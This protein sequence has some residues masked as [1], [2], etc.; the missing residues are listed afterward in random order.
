MNE[1]ASEWVAKADNDYFSAD[2]LLHTG[3]VPIIDTA[4]F[5]CQQCAE[6]Y[7]KAFLQEHT[8]RFER[9]H[10][11]AS[12]LELCALIDKDFNKIADDLDNLEGYAVAIR[13]PGAVVPAEMAEHA[14]ESAT[15]VRDFVRAKLGV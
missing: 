11:L 3:E 15:H 12:L 10:V 9:T 2:M 8:I 13:Y 7:L 6:K 4:C 1:I 14:F 5:H